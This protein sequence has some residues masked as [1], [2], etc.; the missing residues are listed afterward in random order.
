[1]KNR[2]KHAMSTIE[3]ARQEPRLTPEQRAEYERQ[4]AIER[5]QRKLARREKRMQARAEQWWRD[6]RK[7]VEAQP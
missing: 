1:M 3:W 5:Y 6:T 2:R 7:N 4:H